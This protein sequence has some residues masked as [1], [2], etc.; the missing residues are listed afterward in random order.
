MVFTTFSSVIEARRVVDR[1]LKE[2]AIACANITE[3]V[4]S[5]FWWK[6]KID[7]A[8]EVLCIMKARR[9]NLNKIERIIKSIHSYDIPEIIAT[10]IEF[11]S[12]D[13]LKWLNENA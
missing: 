9:V 11:G 2:R 6:G 10:G 4:I 12:K 13:Y 3:G 5:K 8:N 7:T 1:L